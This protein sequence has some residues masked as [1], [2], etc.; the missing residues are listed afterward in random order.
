MK[1]LFP[2][3]LAVMLTC[4]TAA[5]Q[6]NVTIVDDEECGCE[7]YYIDGIE[8]TRSGNLYGFRR[9]DGTVIAPNIYRYV[10]QFHDGY[11]KVMLDDTLV[12]II[13]TNGLHVV[14]CIYDDVQ[15]PAE[16]RVLVGKRGRYGY[17]DL[18]GRVV[19]PLQY[20]AAGSF[21]EGCAAVSVSLDS[22]FSACTFI[23]TMGR[24]LLPAQYESLSAFSN[25]FA[26]VRQ[27]ERW[28]LIDHSGRI[29]L[30]TVYDFVMAL[31]DTLFFAGKDEGMALFDSRM[32]PLT[33]FVY[34]W[35]SDRI[36]D[37]RI[38]VSRNGKYGFLD[39]R[40]REVVS[41]IYDLVGVFGLN[42]AM[43]SLDGH[44]GIVDT[45]GRIVLPVEYDDA[46]S[47]GDK[48]YYSDSLAMVEKDGKVGFVDLDGNLVIPFYF[49]DGYQFSE[50]LASVRYGGKWGYIDTRGEV[51][52]P[53]V[54][55]LASPYLWGRA[56]VH[57]NGL[58]RK[59]DRRGR[60]VKNCKGIIAWRN[61]NE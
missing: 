7:L 22:F 39:R 3:L 41:C 1:P 35:A 46:T 31:D 20:M 26:L 43:V 18:H 60:C 53:F 57:Y 30:P 16:G 10:D 4:G 5:A 12:G 49:N 2:I 42:R 45:A 50:G 21:S 33:P 55:D 38:A 25:G 34:T 13:D 56:T 48:Y 14:P 37:G 52:M 44:F 19:I 32:K 47:K 9:A 61:W 59:V 36:R 51:F 58:S 27:Y 24:Q 23:D 15:Y 40:G 17:T 6:Q 8:T 11:C 28:G 54:F 29:V